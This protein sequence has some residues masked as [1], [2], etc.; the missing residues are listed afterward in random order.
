M[1]CFAK[2]SGVHKA[3]Q[4]GLGSNR[5]DSMSMTATRTEPRYA[6]LQRGA[7]PAAYITPL[8]P[9]LLAAIEGKAAERHRNV[10]ER[11]TAK[12]EELV[13]VGVQL[14]QARIAD[15]RAL[16]DALEHGRKPPK[17]KVH[18]LEVRR[19]ELAH[20]LELLGAR[21]VDA[22]KPLLAAAL[23]VAATVAEQLD[24]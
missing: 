4:R 17:A 24:E 15:E 1:T 2:R 22:A 5:R 21:L 9:S 16:A 6:Q 11:F 14:E 13:T 19:D 18:D 23:P 10:V 3:V 20:E 12:R 7:G 8:P